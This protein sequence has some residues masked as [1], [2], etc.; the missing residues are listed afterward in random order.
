MYVVVL[1][2]RRHRDEGEATQHVFSLVVPAHNEQ[3]VIGDCLRSLLTLDYPDDQFE[4][5]I[6]EDGSSDL[7]ADVVR[8]EAQGLPQRVVMLQVPR[9]EGGRGKASALNRAFQF[10]HETSRFSRAPNWIIG[11]FDADGQPDRDML[12]KASFQFQSPRVGG[13]QA[14]VRI[15]N[16]QKSWLTHMQ[17]IEFAGFSRVTQIIRTRI[18]NSAALGGNGQFVR[19]SA[20][21]DVVLDAAEG[22]Y[23]NPKALTEDLDLSTRLVLRNWDLSHLNTSCVWQEGVETITALMRQRTRWAWGSLQVFGEYVLRMTVFR[24]PNVRLRKRMDLL[25]NLSIFLVSPLIFATWI[26]TGLAFIGLVSVLSSVPGAMMVLLSFAYL[27]VVG[28]GLATVGEYRNRRLPLDL[29]G[30]AIYTYHWVPCLYAGLWHI[31]ARHEPT[32]WKTVRNGETT[33]S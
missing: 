20:I 7:T 11:V 4:I 13:V 23:W 22:V 26:L 1:E 28:Y 33:A 12:K 32:W 27:P 30:F 24:A 16:H 19:A 18:T 14:S 29:I 21:E 5:L 9:H 3:E 15:R 6:L 10:L 2:R 25:F 8:S 17:D 31:V